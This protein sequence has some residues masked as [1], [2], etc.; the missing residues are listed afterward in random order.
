[1]TRKQKSKGITFIVG[2]DIYPFE[3]MFSTEN[4]GQ[5]VSAIQKKGYALNDKEREDLKRDGYGSCTQLEN[6][7]LV[8]QL[9]DQ[10]NN[11]AD[12]GV[13]AHEIFH[14][15]EMLF[16]K[17]GL[18]LCEHSGEAYAYAVQHLMKESLLRFWKSKDSAQSSRKSPVRH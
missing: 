2:F 6:G 17:I 12:I 3:V 7:H 1:M 9:A 13:L 8:I 11:P 14:A 10:P 16:Q 18:S 5:I 4:Y 15:V